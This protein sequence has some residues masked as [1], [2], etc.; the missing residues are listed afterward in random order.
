MRRSPQDHPSPGVGA[1]TPEMKAVMIGA[2]PSNVGQES[3]EMY[4]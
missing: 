3:Y 4:E 2:S 1:S